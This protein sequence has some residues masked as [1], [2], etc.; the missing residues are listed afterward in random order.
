VR[1]K[2]STL[3]VVK[4]TAHRFGKGGKMRA[5]FMRLAFVAALVAALIGG[6]ASEHIWP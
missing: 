1:V 6:S 3:P 4:G 5:R 2:L